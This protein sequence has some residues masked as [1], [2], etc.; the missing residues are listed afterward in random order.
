MY[1]AIVL[2]PLLGRHP[3]RDHRARR[4]ARAFP[5]RRAVGRSSRAGAWAV[6]PCRRRSCRHPRHPPRARRARRSSRTGGTASRGLPRRR[7]HHHL[8]PDDRHGAVLDRALEGRFRPP[9]RA[10][11]AVHLDHLGRSQGRLGAPHRHADRRDAGG[12]DDRLRARASL[13]DRLH[14]RGPVPAAVLRV[15]VAV[16]LRHAGA[17]DRRQPRADVLRLGGRRPRELSADRLLVP[18][19]RGQRRR[20]QGLRRQPRRRFRLRARHLRR[21]HDDEVDRL[22]HHLR[23]GALAHRQDHQLLRL[24][25]RR[26]DLDLPAAVHGRDGQVGAVPAAHLAARRDGRPDAGLGAHSRRD[27]GHR[28]RVHG[29]AAVAA[30]R[31]CAERRGL[32]HA[33]RRHHGVLRRHRRPRAERHQAD[34]RLLDLLAARLHVRRDGR[35]RLFG[36]HVPSVHPRLLQGAFVPR[37]RLGDHGDAPRAGHP[38]HGRA[39]EQDPVHLLVHGDRH[40]GADRLPAHRRLFLQGRHHRGGLFGPQPVRD[41]RLRHDGDRR[42]HDRVLL[43]A[44]D[45]QD[46]PRRAARPAPLRGGA[47][48]PAG[49]PRSAR[50]AGDRL[51][52][53]GLRLQGVLRRPRGRALLPRVAEAGPHH[54]G[55]APRAAPRGVAADRDDGARLGHRRLH[56]SAA[57]GDRAAA[58]APARRAVPLPAQQVVLRRALRPDLRAAG[59]VARPRALEGR[60]RLRHRRLRP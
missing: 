36:R 41:L 27:H 22:R 56:V 50:R 51:A 19:A 48:K 16:H 26:A 55:D 25:R 3:W 53:R 32:R 30:V 52:R 4:R 33:G 15:P 7:G 35:R 45:L 23:A 34:R 12:G 57:S 42:R 28:R 6:G 5:R 18:Q 38:Q 21:V 9:G 44:A 24:A 59:A 43:L 46:L 17:G 54:R 47:R 39:E 14:G 13:F 60:R 2:L 31:A 49:D 20:D 1:L 11:P 10:H 40:P 58:R 37:F 8:A 29:G